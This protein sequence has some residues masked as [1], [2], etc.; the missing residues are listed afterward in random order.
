MN[1]FDLALDK[2][3]RHIVGLDAT[4]DPG[5]AWIKREVVELLQNKENRKDLLLDYEDETKEVL[6]PWLRE[7]TSRFVE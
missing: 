5:L 3:S 6:N 1:D 4:D 7:L 2:L